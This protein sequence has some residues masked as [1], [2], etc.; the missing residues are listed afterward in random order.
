MLNACW[1]TAD[2]AELD[3]AE[4]TREDVGSFVRYKRA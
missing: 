3:T 1:R 4:G 2:G